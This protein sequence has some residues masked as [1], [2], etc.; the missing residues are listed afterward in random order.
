LAPTL[1]STAYVLHVHQPFIEAVFSI[2]FQPASLIYCPVA[3]FFCHPYQTCEKGCA[4]A[5]FTEVNLQHF[6]NSVTWIAQA[7]LFVIQYW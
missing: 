3:Q 1:K 4:Q 5:G 2:A 7:L 6:S